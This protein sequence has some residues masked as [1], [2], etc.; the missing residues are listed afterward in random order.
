MNFDL[1]DYPLSERNGTYGGKAGS[2]EGI[3]AEGEYWIVK[4]PQ[5]TQ[6]MRGTLASYTTA[7]LSEYIGS[8]IYDTHD[9]RPHWLLFDVQVHQ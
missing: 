5:N 8:N 7:P 2:K 1:N 4:Y 9:D 3:I 6:G